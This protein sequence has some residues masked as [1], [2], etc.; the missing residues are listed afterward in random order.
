MYFVQNIEEGQIDFVPKILLQRIKAGKGLE[1]PKDSQ[2]SI[3]FASKQYFTIGK[4]LFWIE[5]QIV[6]FEEWSPF[7]T[8]ETC[9]NMS[10]VTCFYFPFFCL[11]CNHFVSRNDL[12]VC[13]R[14]HCQNISKTFKWLIVFCWIFVAAPKPTKNWRKHGL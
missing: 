13:L 4:Y 1:N 3:Y 7:Q 12:P 2:T 11:I 14:I 9:E 8:L 5:Y 10:A 6:N